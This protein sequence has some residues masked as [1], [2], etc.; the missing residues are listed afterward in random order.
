MRCHECLTDIPPRGTGNKIVQLFRTPDGEDF[1]RCMYLHTG[2]P[3]AGSKLVSAFHYK[4]WLWVKHH[5]HKRE[6]EAKSTVPDPYTMA[7]T[8]MNAE[9]LRRSGL[10]AEEA[11]AA[12]RLLT[13]PDRRV[14]FYVRQGLTEEEARAQ[15]AQE[16]ME[17][18]RQQDMG[19]VER[20]ETDWHEQST[21]EVGDIEP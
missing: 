8:A 10:T 3:P 17:R 16:E 19:Y 9:D 4:C 21:V 14:N 15:V 7:A 11:A 5:G 18:Q 13:T 2:E 6:K 20:E 1:V 12:S